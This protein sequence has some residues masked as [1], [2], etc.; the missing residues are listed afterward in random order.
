MKRTMM[1]INLAATLSIILTACEPATV[2][3]PTDDIQAEI[4]ALQQEIDVYG[5]KWKAGE[6]SLSHLTPE[7]LRVLCGEVSEEVSASMWSQQEA[8]YPIKWSSQPQD[9]PTS[10]DWRDPFFLDWT[11]P[12]RDQGRCGSC[13]AHAA[14]AVLESLVEIDAFDPFLDP[15]LSEADLFSCGCLNCCQKG[16]TLEGAANH[17]TSSGVADEACW[18]YAPANQ[19]CQPGGC[20]RG[21]QIADYKK[22]FTPNEMKQSLVE[23]GPLLGRMV[24]YNDFKHYA[25]GIYQPTPG[26]FAVGGH[27]VAIVGYD[28]MGK[29]WIVK[30][31]WGSDWGENPIFESCS[32]LPSPISNCGWFRISYG[33]A[34]IDDYAIE[35]HLIAPE[36]VPSEI[37]QRVQVLTF[38]ADDMNWH[39][40]NIVIDAKVSVQVIISGDAC[41]G[42]GVPCTDSR[43]VWLPMVKVN[44]TEKQLPEAYFIITQEWIGDTGLLSFAFGDTYY[45]DN[46]GQIVIRIKV[47]ER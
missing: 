45:G 13:V 20:L 24:V 42:G 26:S 31:S 27:A 18:S 10:F 33:A 40:T 32:P 25:G 12:I 22:L 30:N 41:P 37:S 38:N 15:D 8:L 1:L 36:S 2:V 11:T 16:W 23:N 3:E 7:E 44:S 4:T 21:Q 6:T 47:I 43:F 35:L 28:D 9:L 46:T 39:D 5:L 34:G 14:L 17:L 19:A 29:Y